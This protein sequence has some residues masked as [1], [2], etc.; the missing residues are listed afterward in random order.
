MV[1][2]LVLTPVRPEND[3]EYED[4]SVLDTSGEGEAEGEGQV[5]RERKRKRETEGSS[6]D[7]GEAEDKGEEGEGEEEGPSDF[8][9]YRSSNFQ[10]LKGWALRAGIQYLESVQQQVDERKS[11]GTVAGSRQ[12]LSEAGIL[13]AATSKTDEK[14]LEDASKV[15]PPAIHLLRS[16][17]HEQT[18][19][20]SGRYPAMPFLGMLR[21]G[22]PLGDTSNPGPAVDNMLNFNFRFSEVA[23]V[24]F[25]PPALHRVG[26]GGLFYHAKIPDNNH[27][28]Y[29]SQ[30][31][32]VAAALARVFEFF[33]QDPQYWK[34]IG[35]ELRDLMKR[36]GENELSVIEI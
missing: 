4:S 34:E 20:E 32:L 15:I 19:D 25:C 23:K 7:E 28:V 6:E 3:D 10:D 22:I 27:F 11:S 14:A 17:L 12:F 2:S 33:P 18:M 13:A 30:A 24:E 1:V 9:S 21:T 36:C 35:G 5:E 31:R 8:W 26:L 16:W 29:P